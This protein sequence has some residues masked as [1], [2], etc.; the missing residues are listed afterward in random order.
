MQQML[1]SLLFMVMVGA[2]LPAQPPA[3]TFHD[4]ASAPPTPLGRMQVRGLVAQAS[5]I[6]ITELPAGLKTTPHHHHQEQM[7]LGLR[8]G[9][10]YLMAGTPNTLEPLTAALALPNV[11]HGNLNDTPEPSVVVEY[12]AVQR[13]DWF[14]PHPRRPR[15][16]APAP[17]AIAAGRKVIENFSASSGGWQTHAGGARSKSLTGDTIRLTLWQLPAGAKPVLLT[18]GSAV[19]RLVLVVDGTASIGDGP[20]RRDIGREML[21]IVAPSATAVTLGG[22]AK[23]ASVVALYEPLAP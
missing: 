10:K 16:G 14:P 3:L 2:S 21:V 1:M 9:M 12:Q 23:A 7:M 22:S 8:G 11:E 5:S 18:T 4:L 15:E 13:P 6:M 17:V 20:T 19:E